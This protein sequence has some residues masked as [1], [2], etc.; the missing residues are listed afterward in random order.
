MPTPSSESDAPPALRLEEAFRCA[1]TGELSVRDVRL[2]LDGIATITAEPA[3]AS[4][5]LGFCCALIGVDAMSH[6]TVCCYSLDEFVDG[7]LFDPTLRRLAVWTHTEAALLVHVFDV[8]T[9]SRASFSH[10]Y[11]LQC[12]AGQR[13]QQRR[14][15]EQRAQ[16]R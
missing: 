14:W 2:S 3:G 7:G 1:S 5:R 6:R 16:R 11:L 4:P 15:A 8:S 9:P 10:R 13:V 12:P